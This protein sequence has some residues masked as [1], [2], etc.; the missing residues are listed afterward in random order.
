MAT[1]TN[2]QRSR[3]TNDWIGEEYSLKKVRAD[4]SVADIRAAINAV[5]DWIE[6][7]QAGFNAALP[8]PFR[9]VATAGQKAALFSFVAL[10]KY[11][12]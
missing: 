4:L 3:A 7:N 12:G 11:R 6:A 2:Q 1:L 5:D 9:N 8:L 10:K